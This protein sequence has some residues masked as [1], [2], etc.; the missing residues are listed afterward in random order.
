MWYWRAY[1][2]RLPRRRTSW[3][4]TGHS[5]KGRAKE[6]VRDLERRDLLLT[7]DAAPLQKPGDA[8]FGE[9]AR[10]FWAWEGPYVQARLRFSDPTS[11]DLTRRYVNDMSR[12]L[13]LHLLPRWKRAPLIS[14]TPLAIETWAL[15]IRDDGLSGKRVNDLISC[16]RTMLKE[17][18]REGRLS[19]DPYAKG[20]VRALGNTP[21]QRGRLTMD[22]VRRLFADEA[23][24]TAWK[25]HRLYR[26]VNLTAAATGMRQGELLALRDH[27]VRDGYLHVEHSWDHKWGLG[28]TKTRQIRDVPLPSRAREA[29]AQFLGSGGFVFS[30]DGG[31]RPCSGNRV[32]G[33]LYA[34]LQLI[35]V[36]D[37]AER[38][39]TFH[40]W[41]HWL[42]TTL[43]VEGV[44]DALIRRVVGHETPQ[45][46]ERYSRYNP[47][48][49]EAVAVVQEAVFG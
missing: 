46:T 27:D 32:T 35:G 25:G 1:D 43:R 24:A 29:L 21:R 2:E 12:I 41:R 3:R 49:F 48:D 44:P 5:Q 31:H 45:M 28:P 33:A 30:M 8:L 22:E 42:N 14:I 47:E 9:W 6:Y 17:A 10:G 20:I 7:P 40:S 16:L 19:F 37:R 15:R 11:P 23:I 34:A 39:V 18:H 4:S 38:N 26:A 13:E 36:K